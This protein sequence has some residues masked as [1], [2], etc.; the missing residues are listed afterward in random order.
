MIYYTLAKSS[1][2]LFFLYQISIINLLLFIRFNLR[3]SL[4]LLKILLVFFAPI[5]TIAIE[6]G[7][8][9]NNLLG[10]SSDSSFNVS[11]YIYNV[12]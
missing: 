4:F 9:L 3:V 2:K 8:T 7:E 11:C 1:L 12:S 6:Q 10:F 5:L